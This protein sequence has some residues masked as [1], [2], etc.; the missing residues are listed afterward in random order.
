MPQI[1]LEFMESIW[2]DS[3]SC[4]RQIHH[5]EILRRPFTEQ[6]H[7]YSKL[8]SNVKSPS[9][10]IGQNNPVK[11]ILWARV[12]EGLGRPCPGKA[13]GITIDWLRL[14]NGDWAFEPLLQLAVFLVND[15]YIDSTKLV[16]GLASFL[17][18]TWK[19]GAWPDPS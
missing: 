9:I 1:S 2:N 4:L 10:K 7:T 14:Q 19:A 11:N 5:T 17:S 15:S 8:V 13:D 3:D 6:H 18:C 16:T 12:F